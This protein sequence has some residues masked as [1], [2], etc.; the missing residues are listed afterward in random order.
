MPWDHL[1][2]SLWEVLEISVISM[3]KSQAQDHISTHV[4]GIGAAVSGDSGTFRKCRIAG[5][6]C[7]K[8][9]SLSI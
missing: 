7:Y 8:G 1:R 5:G 2:I 9:K 3:K 6:V 4:Y